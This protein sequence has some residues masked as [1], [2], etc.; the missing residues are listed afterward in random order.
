MLFVN[1]IERLKGHST[2]NII[3]ASNVLVCISVFFIQWPERLP[4]I[5]LIR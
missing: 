4:H 1:R 5:N 2:Y 3:I